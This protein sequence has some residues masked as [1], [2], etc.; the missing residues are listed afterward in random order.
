MSTSHF[1]FTLITLLIVFGSGCS[2]I[3]PSDFYE[4]DGL[5]S[6]ALT[7]SFEAPGWHPVQFINSEGLEFNPDS[8]ANAG[9]LS[10]SVYIS[11]P[12][13]YS[14]W[15]LAASGKK[16]ES[17]TALDAS[18]SGQDGY[19][20][21]QLSANLTDEY[22]LRWIRFGTHSSA[23]LITIDDAGQYSFS[24]R[25]RNSE[26]IHIHKFQLSR[27][28]I[29]PPFG[30]G[31]PSSTGLDLSAAD[32][33]REIPV[34][35]PPA[36][37]FKPVIGV[38]GMFD[39]S[40]GKPDGFA[41]LHSETGGVW[42]DAEEDTDLKNNSAGLPATDTATGVKM[43]VSKTCEDR[44]AQIFESGYRFIVTR[45]SPGVE[46]LERIHQ[47]FQKID[48]RD[49]R[50]IVFHGIK[51]AH[52]SESKRFPAPMIPAY[53]F[54]W[55]AEPFVQ[56]GDFFP[57][58]YQELVNDLT[59][60]ANSL[61]GMPF[62]SMPI[63]YQSRMDSASGW[64]SELFI[65]TV[66]LSPFIPVMNLV[67][68]DNIFDEAGLSDHLNSLEKEQLFDALTL[69]TSLFPYHYSHAHY[70]R[71][72]NEG[73]ISGF[74]QYPRQY[75]YGDAFLVAPVTEPNAE[76][77]IVFFPEGRRW[78]NYYSGQSYEAGQSWF[79]ET[80]RDQL[81]LFVKAGSVIPYHIDE[82]SNHLKIDIYTGDAGA[83]R[84]VED[85]GT[86]RAYR[87]AEAARTMFRYNEV[88][89]NLKLTIG[90][91][92]AEFEGMTAQRSYAIHFKFLD[93]PDLVEI[94]G[95]KIN[96]S[97]MD[98]QVMSWQYIESES[99]VV[100]TMNSVSKHEKFDVIIHP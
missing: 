61:Y 80:R 89:G 100:V 49:R 86:T 81:P 42:T 34:M 64:D 68:P 17:S 11:N 77:R 35:L 25:P 18:V 16:T 39:A 2:T 31:L 45:D 30:L 20:I 32:L 90:A 71:Q 78:Y 50:S 82:T 41:M 70:T 73:I 29:D 85:D 99:E 60:P 43:S 19:L 59:D 5:V 52:K 46:C 53:K 37:I 12:G 94:N 48:G 83:I 54:E 57:G 3:P 87:R 93:D 84:L 40:T 27:D 38:T 58:G 4:V 63:D 23:N 6:G 69:R 74:R 98:S 97:S 79:V 55:T 26:N 95:S 72:T 91:V 14:F 13:N 62:L 47:T 75:M 22:R 8:S 96:R 28:N 76:G 88:E 7:D 56:G 10:F 66:Q 65:R 33:F 9:P 1:C 21:S 36:W 51:N 15:I 44:A 92:Q 24:I 67:L